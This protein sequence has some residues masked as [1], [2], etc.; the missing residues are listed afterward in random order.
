MKKNIAREKA[1][2]KYERLL[3]S[4]KKSID[5][6]KRM[7]LNKNVLIRTIV[8]TTAS[9]RCEKC[10]MVVVGKEF[11]SDSIRFKVL[12]Q[13]KEDFISENLK[14]IG[15]PYVTSKSDLIPIKFKDIIEWKEWNIL[16]DAAL[17]VG[18]DY[19]SDEFKKLAFEK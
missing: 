18:F 16:E 3:S 4:F 11:N 10:D 9:N 19:L 2:N 5:L 6:I 8:R 7:P 1:L 17:V 14:K 12:A 15:K 13:E